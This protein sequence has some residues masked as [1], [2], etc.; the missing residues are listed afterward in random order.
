MTNELEIDGCSGCP[1]QRTVQD[2]GASWDVCDHPKFKKQYGKDLPKGKGAPI[3]CPLHQDV[4]ILKL[5]RD[6]W[7]VDKND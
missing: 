7:P 6:F 5:V 1:L 4:L 2:H 3:W